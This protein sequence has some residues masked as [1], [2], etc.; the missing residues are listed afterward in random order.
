MKDTEII[1]MYWERDE[2]AI[3]ESQ[4]CYGNYCHS[5]AYRILQDQEDS[6]ECVNDT[7][8][9]AWNA[10]PPSRP[11]RL[12]IFLG[13]ITRNLSFDRWKYKNAHK[14]GKGKMELAL[15]ELVECVP[16]SYSV[17]DQVETAQLAQAINAF[18]HT[19][20][21]RDCNV[22]LRRYWYVEEYSEIA[23]RYSMKLGTV[24]TVLFRV[25]QQL[26]QYLEKQG[27]LY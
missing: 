15:D 9:R 7:W 4:A 5:I 22:F 10:I 20:P 21:E 1:N 14:R 13:T 11:N 27:M 3:T 18:L 23:Q 6:E 24:K 12:A 25:R 8:L 19:L 2:R 26:R 16:D 17:E